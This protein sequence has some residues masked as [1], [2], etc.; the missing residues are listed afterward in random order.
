MDLLILGGT[1]WV[2][3][4]L[5][6]EAL[7]RGHAV[8]CLA[9]GEAGEVA[10]GADLVVADRTQPGAYDAVVDREWDAVIDVTRE[11]LFA[12]EAAAALA[13]KARLGV[14][15]ST[16]NV[17]A[18]HDVPGG[19][20]SVELLPPLEADRSTPETYGEA[21]VACELAYRAAFGD[22]LLIVR[23][24]LIGGPGDPSGR[25]GSYVVRAARDTEAPMLVPDIP[26]AAA[27]F[28][29]V[30]DLVAWVLQAVEDGLTGT[31]NAVGDRSTFGALLDVSR[32]VGGHAGE[33]V[34]APSTWLESRGVNEW[35][36][37]DSLAFWIIDPSWS[38]FQ[39]RSNTAAVHAGLRVRPVED[40]L[41]DVLAWER[42][43]GLDRER[44]AGLS[45][46]REAELIADWRAS[47]PG[48]QTTT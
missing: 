6:A 35:S 37:P 41:G 17:Y 25:T 42:E 15:I 38:G 1:Q 12:R 20:E 31:F 7:A 4:A 47:G 11:P 39:D 18:H 2:G 43:Q 23:P 16:G 28:I 46:A 44:G 8:T 33:V 48:S 29:D 10:P 9:R 32:Q 24:G 30:R 3:R 19:D 13:P 36:G 27:Q 26:E 5:A 45:P 21:K 14:F 22:R 34:A 40:S